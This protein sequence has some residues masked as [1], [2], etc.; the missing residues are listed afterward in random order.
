MK[1]NTQISIPTSFSL[2]FLL[3]LLIPNTTQHI[4]ADIHIPHIQKISVIN[5]KNFEDLKKIHLDNGYYILKDCVELEVK[6]NTNWSLV[7]FDESSNSYDNFLLRTNSLPFRPLTSE[8]NILIALKKPTS[9]TIIS[10]DCKRSVDWGDI[11]R[12][13]WNFSPIFKLINLK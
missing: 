13:S 5:Q 6:S 8:E 4:H 1:S 7:V 10:I 12:S 2:F 11:Q 3:G 9:S